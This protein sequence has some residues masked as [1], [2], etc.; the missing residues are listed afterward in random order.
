MAAETEIPHE[1]H[2]ELSP[3]PIAGHVQ[4][5]GRVPTHA[6]AADFGAVRSFAFAGTEDKQQLLPYDK[7]RTE[8][9]I[10]VS[11]IGPVYMGSEAQCAQVRTA[12]AGST[13]TCGVFSASTTP[14][15]W[16]NKSALWCIPDQT[17]P[18]T[19]T[20]IEERNQA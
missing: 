4:I 6:E 17:H 8:A 20:V 10:L 1:E 9:R 12:G 7:H 3:V 16:R 14:V 18:V 11:G 2:G 5:S 13:L 19:V 15:A